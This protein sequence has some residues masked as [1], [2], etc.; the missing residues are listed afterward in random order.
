MPA[1][2]DHPREQ[3]PHRRVVVGQQYVHGALLVL[4]GPRYQRG[5]PKRITVAACVPPRSVSNHATATRPF[6][7][8]TVGRD[9]TD[10]PG[11]TAC[12]RSKMCPAVFDKASQICGESE[13]GFS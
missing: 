5:V 9:A 1:L 8:A 2:L 10:V 3:E 6:R 12:L 7:T 11:D 4:C 13:F